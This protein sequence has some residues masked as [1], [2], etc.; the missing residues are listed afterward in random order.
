M[1]RPHTVPVLA[2]DQVLAKENVTM[3]PQQR[4]RLDDL[5][6]LGDSQPGRYGIVDAPL[7]ERMRASGDAEHRTKRLNARC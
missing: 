4:V 5:D 2:R 6:D 3:R 1:L 7:L